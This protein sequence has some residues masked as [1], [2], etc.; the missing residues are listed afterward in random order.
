MDTAPHLQY[1]FTT[2]ATIRRVWRQF[3]VVGRVVIGC[4]AHRPDVFHLTTSYDRAWG[5]DELFLEI[6]GLFGAAAILNI[7]GGDFGRFYGEQT[8]SRK[9]KILRTLKRCA[10]VVVVTTETKQ[11]LQSLGLK[12]IHVI[13]NC[14]DIRELDTSRRDLNDWLYV[15]WVT[16][17]KG[18][19]ELLD[20]LRMSP[21]ARLTLVG[22]IV[23]GNGMSRAE[24]QG[25]LEDEAVA[26]RIRHIP[27]AP[28]EQARAFC[29]QHGVFVFPTRRDG[30]PNSVLEAM[31]AGMPIVSTAVGGIPDMLRDGIDALLV[32][33]R[34]AVA[35]ARALATISHSSS[36][37]ERLAAAAR[38]RVEEHYSTTAVARRWFELYRHCSKLQSIE[39][40]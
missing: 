14:I 5:R 30:F 11:F 18:L 33:P 3:G 10:A 31:E 19:V 7:R 21:Q 16:P 20:A 38:S 22:P 25:L 8:E 29:R 23:E 34:D 1:H 27:G 24:I 6:A 26:Q 4:V 9:A 17:A 35:L 15:G 32:P 39:N 36:I 12:N 28:Q 2:R 40:I 37:A 13:P